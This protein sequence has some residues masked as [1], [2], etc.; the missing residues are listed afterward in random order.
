MDGIQPMD[1]FIILIQTQQQV[2]GYGQK[3]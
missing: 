3:P 2:A 1:V